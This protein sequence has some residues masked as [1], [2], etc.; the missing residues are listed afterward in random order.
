M[1]LQ[2]LAQV[3]QGAE[4]ACGVSSIPELS[5][6]T[7]NHQQQRAGRSHWHRPLQESVPEDDT[8]SPKGQQSREFR[9]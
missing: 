8:S 5:L 9:H 2:V 6:V 4:P 3:G 7:A 1:L